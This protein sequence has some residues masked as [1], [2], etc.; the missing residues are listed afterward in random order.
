MYFKNLMQSMLG[1]HNV[2]NMNNIEVMLAIVQL[3]VCL[4]LHIS[5]VRSLFMIWFQELINVN[6]ASSFNGNKSKH[7][8]GWP[9]HVWALELKQHDTSAGPQTLSLSIHWGLAWGVF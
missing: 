5:K 8:T 2:Q 7:R 6:S 9:Q 1:S 4:L 3:R